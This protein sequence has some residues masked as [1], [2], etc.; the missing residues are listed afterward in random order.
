M[1][2]AES[3]GD[4][5]NDI[6]CDYSTCISGKAFSCEPGSKNYKH[7]STDILLSICGKLHL[8]SD[9]EMVLKKHEIVYEVY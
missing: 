2:H 6:C 3:H 7:R 8:Q 4:E 5:A 9:V 1:L